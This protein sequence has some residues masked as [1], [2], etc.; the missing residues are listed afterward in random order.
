[1]SQLRMLIQKL[2]SSSSSHANKNRFSAKYHS[3]SRFVHEE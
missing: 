3:Y 1:M 2:Q